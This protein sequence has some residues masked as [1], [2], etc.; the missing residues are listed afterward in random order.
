[1]CELD[2]NLLCKI[3]QM[4][5][6]VSNQELM[7]V[8]TVQR[9]VTFALLQITFTAYSAFNYESEIKQ[10]IFNITYLTVIEINSVYK[11]Y[12]TTEIFQSSFSFMR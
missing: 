8:N 7:Y 12:Q 2:W 9:I 10:T 11:R 1:M 4:H 3:G 6:F 5:V